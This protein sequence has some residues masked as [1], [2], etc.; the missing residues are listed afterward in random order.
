MIKIGKEICFDE[1]EVCGVQDFRDLTQRL[2]SRNYESLTLHK[3]VIKGENHDTVVNPG[4]DK[5]I[6]QVFK[7][8]VLPR[9]Y[10][11]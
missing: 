10:S 1:G 2:K 6:E 3:R 5:G 9:K 11:F 4:Y 7:A 8:K